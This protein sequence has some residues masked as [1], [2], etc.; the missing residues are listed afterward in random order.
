MEEKLDWIFGVVGNIVKTHS[1]EYGVVY[2]G[3]K[4]FTGGTKV[5]LNGKYWDSQCENIAVI[6]RNRF[7]RIVFERVPVEL[8]E[9]VRV[10]R[11]Y[12]PHVLEIIDYLRW[13]EGLE[14]W[15]RT[16]ADRRDTERFVK[17]WN[18]RNNK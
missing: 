6:G 3:T 8:L 12:K 4:A 15:E 1:G 5:Y 2:Y 11:I 9:N 14:W 13:M 18:D 7:G 16:S 17:E 10:Q